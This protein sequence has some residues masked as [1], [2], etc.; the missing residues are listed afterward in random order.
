MLSIPL[1]DIVENLQ[2]AGKMTGWDT[3][4]FFSQCFAVTVLFVALWFFAWKKVRTVLEER[5]TA[6]E[7][8]MAN[9][10]RIKKELADAEATRLDI[11][12]KANDQ[13]NAVITSAHETA[14]KLAEQGARGATTQAEEIIRRA[15]EAAILDRDRLM[16]ELKRDIGALVIQTTEKIAG[17]VLTPADQARLNDETL[18]RLGAN[19]N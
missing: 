14:A 18:H 9:A 19:N 2:N 1:A 5:R 16:A 4:H 15:H 6:I 11:I 17:K 7:Q 3:Q 10:D 12:R 8:S 13:A